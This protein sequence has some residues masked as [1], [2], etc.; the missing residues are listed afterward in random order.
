FCGNA[1][2]DRLDA[3]G[4]SQSSWEGVDYGPQHG[5]ESVQR[6]YDAPYHRLPFLQPGTGAVGA[7]F[8]PTHMTVE[9]GTS[10]ETATVVSPSDGQKNIGL[11]WHGPESPDPLAIH[12]VDGTCGYPIVFGYFSPTMDKIVV[13]GATL[14]TTRGEDVPFWLNTPANDKDL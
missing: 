9:F 5:S 14:R 11:S 13:D 2:G 1:P 10:D 12:G 3:F 7:G 4:F 8:V 6:L